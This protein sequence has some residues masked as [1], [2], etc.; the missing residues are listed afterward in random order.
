M[1]KVF[2][3]VAANEGANLEP[4]EIDWIVGV[5]SVEM[6]VRSS[7]LGVVK[8]NSQDLFDAMVQLRK[9]LQQSGRLLLCSGAR[10]DAYPS[11]MMLEMGGGKK[12]YLLHHGRPAA[13]D[14]LMDIFDPAVYLQVG[15]VEEQRLGYEEWL[16]SLT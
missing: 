15:T 10:K 4:C 1:T 3:Q 12:V 8:I 14:D 6:V 2:V 11:R 5:A 9:Q 7:F 13:K 16:R